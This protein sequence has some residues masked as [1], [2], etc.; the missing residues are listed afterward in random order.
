MECDNRAYFVDEYDKCMVSVGDPAK[1]KPVSIKSE[2]Y[3]FP[4]VLAQLLASCLWQ[5]DRN[6]ELEEDWDF[7]LNYTNDYLSLTTRGL[8]TKSS[9]NVMWWHLK[10]SNAV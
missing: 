8:D 3:L 4:Y 10:V 5:S 6:Q 1:E 2:F 7:G 9:S